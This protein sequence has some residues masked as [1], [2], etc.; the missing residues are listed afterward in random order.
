[1][2]AKKKEAVSCILR[3]LFLFGYTAGETRKKL[4][5]E[6]RKEGFTE[7][8]CKAAIEMHG[9]GKDVDEVISYLEQALKTYK[10]CTNKKKWGQWK[11][12]R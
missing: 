1:M 10:F 11:Y 7:K 5:L 2:K 4:F 8:M 3:E 9:A 6:L 12:E